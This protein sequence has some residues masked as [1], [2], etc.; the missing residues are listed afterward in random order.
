MKRF[1][2]VFE[3]IFG[4]SLHGQ[5]EATCVMQALIILSDDEGFVDLTFRAFVGR[6]G[7]PEAFVRKGMHELMSP[8]PNSRTPG[9]EGRR[10]LPVVPADASEPD[11]VNGWV[12]VNYQK[13]ERLATKE[14]KREADRKRIRAKRKAERDRE[15]K[16]VKAEPST[17]S[18]FPNFP[19]V[20]DRVTNSSEWNL[21]QQKLDEY[22]ATYEHLDVERQLH[23]ALQ[24]LR[25]N[26]QKKKTANGMFRF[27]NSWLSRTQNSGR[28]SHASVSTQ[29]TKNEE[30]QDWFDWGA[31]DDE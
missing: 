16:A 18:T 6:T 24:W 7:W 2:K 21:P 26:P 12:L 11:E 19:I 25:D 5:L 29:A 9:C 17:P 22:K 15:K 14:G 30:K 27:L 4:G 1:G 28:H 8:D 3:S 13:Y 31:E 20:F 10:I 23:I